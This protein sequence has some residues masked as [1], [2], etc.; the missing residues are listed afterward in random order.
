MRDIS[1]LTDKITVMPD[2][3]GDSGGTLP[4]RHWY[5]AIVNNK[6][7]RRTAERLDALGYETYVASQEEVRQ[8]R[9]GRRRKV[10]RMV[11]PGLVFIKATEAERRQ[12]LTGNLVK[13]YLS[14]RAAQRPQ[15][16]NAPPAIIPEA[17]LERLRFML[18]QADTPVQFSDRPLPPGTRVRVIRGPL[19]GL[20][21]E[22]A[23][24]A[25]KDNNAIL[26]VRLDYLGCALLDVAREDIEPE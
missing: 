25:S 15:G 26:H 9:D 5:V 3:M 23:R 20:E 18:G 24:S 14:D 11:I 21:G 17:Q 4:E 6:S 2:S 13:R 22:I 1:I 8:W 7:E 16:Y 12:T 19:R 10:Q